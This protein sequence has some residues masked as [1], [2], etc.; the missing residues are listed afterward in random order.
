MFIRQDAMQPMSYMRHQGYATNN[1]YPTTTSAH[2][3]QIETRTRADSIEQ[4]L[5]QHLLARIPGQFQQINTRTRS[6]EPAL[7]IARVSNTELG[8]ETGKPQ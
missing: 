6:R 3:T 5:P 7:I 4:L 2:L 8:I 1:P